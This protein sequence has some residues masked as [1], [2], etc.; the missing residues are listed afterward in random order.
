MTAHQEIS[1]PGKTLFADPGVYEGRPRALLR[2]GRRHAP[3]AP[4]RAGRWCCTA[5]PTVIGPRGLLPEAGAGGTRRTSSR[6]STVAS[7]RHRAGPA[8]GHLVVGD[9]EHACG[10]LANQ[11][12]VWSCTAGSPAPTGPRP[13]GP[14]GARPRPAGR[15][16]RPRGAAPRRP[17]GRPGHLLGRARALRR[18]LMATGGRGYHVVAP[19]DRVRGLR[20]GPRAG[21]RRS[22]TGSPPMRRTTLTTE[23]R[24]AAR[25]GRIVLDTRTAT[26]TARRRSTP[27]SPRGTAPGAPVAPRRS[28]FAELGTRSHPTA[29]TRRRSCA[30][31][32]ASPSWVIVAHAGSAARARAALG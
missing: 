2:T 10:C 1:R 20:R 18:Y 25:G 30:A 5:S 4:G 24:I 9:V 23:Q 3:A 21:A 28:G 11:A 22:P 26:P 17:Q 6:P 7:G 19:V 8:C 27:Y 32:P 13:P 15:R 14:A 12:V 31:W 29:T 16:R